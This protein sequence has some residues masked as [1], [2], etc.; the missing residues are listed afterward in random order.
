MNFI[1][2]DLAWGPKNNT[3]LCLVRDGAALESCLVRTDEEILAWLRPLT[4][5][6]CLVAIDAP[7]VVTNPSGR[8]RCESLISRVFNRSQAGAHSSNLGLSAFSNGVR[9]MRLAKA[10]DLEHDPRI[11]PGLPV[12]RAVEVYPH[13]ALIAL[14][15]LDLSLKYKQKRGR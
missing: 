10:L 1:G 9:A 15:A 8:R 12:R 13:P 7:L 4:I 6:P 2:V 3:G 11:E 14:C 5:G